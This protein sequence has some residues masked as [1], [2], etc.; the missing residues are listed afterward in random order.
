MAPILP[1]GQDFKMQ[2]SVCIVLYVSSKHASGLL[3]VMRK[4]KT[5]TQKMR[6]RIGS[7]ILESL[8]DIIRNSTPSPL[9]FATIISCIF[10]SVHEMLSFEAVQQYGQAI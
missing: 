4:L 9:P 6:G 5:A 2:M 8:K 10:Q 3:R 1:N 7:F